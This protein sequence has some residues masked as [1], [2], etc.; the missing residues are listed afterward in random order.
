MFTK[1]FPDGFFVLISV[2]GTNFEHVMKIFIS[3][4]L[5]LKQIPVKQYPPLLGIS[6]IWNHPVWNL[7]LYEVLSAF[8]WKSNL[9]LFRQ[10]ES[11]GDPEG[12]CPQLS[13]LSLKLGDFPK[14]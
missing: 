2:L 14:T 12:L 7:A 6:M 1:S 8:P 4:S 10:R 5:T 11:L 13:E 9:T 3:N